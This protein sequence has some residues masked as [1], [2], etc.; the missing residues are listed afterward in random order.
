MINSRIIA[1]GALALAAMACGG[2]SG[3]GPGPNNPNTAA[4]NKITSNPQLAAALGMGSFGMIMAGSNLSSAGEVTIDG[5]TYT[6]YGVNMFVEQDVSSI[7]GMPV[8]IEFKAA[9][10]G[11]IGI[12]MEGDN[13][14]E[15][16]SISMTNVDANGLF[17][18]GSGSVGSGSTPFT[19]IYFKNL[20]KQN[21]D[22]YVGTTGQ[23]Q[24]TASPQGG[25]QNCPNAGVYATQLQSCK[26]G[27][28]NL[29]G[30]F[31]F[32]AQPYQGQG[33]GTISIPSTSFSVPTVDM[34]LKLKVGL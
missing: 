7:P 3:T 13:V 33:A 1:T 16:F 9:S 20:D 15:G 5:S 6:I 17:T 14:T 25:T 4:I 34:T 23:A 29:Q 18:S 24:F 31:S 28:G 10:A 30:S 21:P 19:A 12:R 32:T 11:V 2:D 22:I 8:G 27:R 26:F